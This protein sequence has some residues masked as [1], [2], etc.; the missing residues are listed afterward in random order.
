MTHKLKVMSGRSPLNWG[1]NSV[2]ET[3]D[4]DG[5]RDRDRDGDGYGDGETVPVSRWAREKAV[6]VRGGC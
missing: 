6:G 5:D 2:A 1:K 4:G 3:G